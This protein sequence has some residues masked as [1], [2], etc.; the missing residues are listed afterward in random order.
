V[1]LARRHLGTGLADAAAD[2]Q[3][4]GAVDDP[5]WYGSRN[6]FD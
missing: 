5:R 3:R 4:Q 6:Q 1:G 2:R